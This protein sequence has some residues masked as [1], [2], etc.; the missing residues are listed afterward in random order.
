[1][2]KIVQ[3]NTGYTGVTFTPNLRSYS[4]GESV[5]LTDAEYA[6]LPS[7]TLSAITVTNGSVAD[8]ARINNP[9]SLTDALTQA[10]AYSDSKWQAGSGA[11]TI[12]GKLGDYY[13]RRDTPSTVNQR[14]YVCT[15]AGAAGAA[16]WVG[17]V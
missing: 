10:Q 11:P 15:V 13:L 6:A 7:N 3:V 5:T 9:S 4:A 16:T 17:I 8:P 12:A 14:I 1:M 2:G